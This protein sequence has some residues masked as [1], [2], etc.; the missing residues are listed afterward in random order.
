MTSH[1]LTEGRLAVREAVKAA[2]AEEMTI[3][4]YRFKFLPDDLLRGRALKNLGIPS[5]PSRFDGRP[6][7]A[8]ARIG[9]YFRQRVRSKPTDHSVVPSYEGPRKFFKVSLPR[10]PGVQC[11]HGAPRRIR[12]T[13]TGAS[14]EAPSDENERPSALSSHEVFDSESSLNDDDDEFTVPRKSR[15]SHSFQFQD[16]DERPSAQSSHEV[17]DSESSLNDDDDEF[18]VPRVCRSSDA[19]QSKDENKRPSAQ[20]SHEIFDSESSLN[21]DDDE[22]TVLRKSMSSDS[23]QFEDED[24]RPSAQSSHQVSDS[25]SSLND[26]DDEFTVLRK[27]RSRDSS[28]FRKLPSL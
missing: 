10:P 25:E 18:T 26:D 6:K 8:W 23:S 9:P 3:L 11:L 7:I 13:V 15:S 2:V 28:Q 24:K 4:K 1:Q 27:S 21:D 16:E 20:R 22:F 5:L 19:S 12:V 14:T 17:F